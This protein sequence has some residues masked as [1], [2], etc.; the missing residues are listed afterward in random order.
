MY[1]MTNDS[2]PVEL[3]QDELNLINGLKVFLCFLI[4]DGE[5]E[6]MPYNQMIRNLTRARKQVSRDQLKSGVD[7]L[8][9]VSKGL[10]DYEAK[11]SRRE[12]S[13][14]ELAII[15]GLRKMMDFLYEKVDP[16]KLSEPKETKCYLDVAERLSE[17]NVNDARRYLEDGIRKLLPVLRK[18]IVPMVGNSQ[19]I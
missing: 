16:K 8:W 17:V 7:N 3:T 18:L 11:E 9:Y 13:M 14:T 10:I 19:E 4:T 12:L 6:S 5:L 15:D 2:Q 1:Q